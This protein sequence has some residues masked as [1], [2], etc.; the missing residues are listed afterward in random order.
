MEEVIIAVIRDLPSTAIL[1]LF[2]LF[3]S[4]QFRSAT[5]MLSDHLHQLNQ[6]IAKCMQTKEIEEK[7]RKIDRKLDRMAIM[8]ARLEKLEKSTMWPDDDD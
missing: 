1:I 3:V 5:E 8:L 4:R 7:E 6:L 2:I